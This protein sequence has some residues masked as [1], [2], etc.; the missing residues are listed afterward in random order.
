[1]SFSFLFIHV[2]CINQLQNI[3]SLCIFASNA[4][5]MS[6]NLSSKS[7]IK[8]RIDKTMISNNFIILTIEQCLSYG[9]YS[10]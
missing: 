1:M 9:W 3:H 8:I 2:F 6:I 4:N 7:N 10:N 5:K